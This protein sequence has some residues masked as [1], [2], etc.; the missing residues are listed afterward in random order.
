MASLRFNLYMKKCLFTGED[1][2]F[3]EFFISISDPPVL[4]N[5]QQLSEF[6]SD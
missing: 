3:G 6:Y 1:S 5:R 2:F 4:T